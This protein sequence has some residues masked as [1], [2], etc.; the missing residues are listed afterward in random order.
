MCQ[1][2]LL[3]SKG[4]NDRCFTRQGAPDSEVYS[5]LG[6]WSCETRLVTSLVS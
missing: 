1:L 2:A 6:V 4:L 5:S 3:G